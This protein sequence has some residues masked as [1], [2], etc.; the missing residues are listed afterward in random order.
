MRLMR[1]FLFALLLQTA[2]PASPK[3]ILRPADFAPLT[4]LPW[5]APDAT[6]EGSLRAIFREPDAS[7]RY[8]VLAEYLWTIP[9]AQLGRA[10]DLSLALEG[11][12]D[13]NELVSSFLEIWAARDPV[14]CWKRTQDLFQVTGF[15]EDW[16]S[17]SDWREPITVQDSN[18]IQ[19]SPYWLGSSALEGFPMGVELSSA[20]KK[21]R[22]RLMREFADQW[23]DAFATWPGGF[24]PGG[25][26]G[27]AC[28]PAVIKAFS[29]SM[30]GFATSGQ[31]DSTHSSRGEVEVEERRWL[32]ADPA[33]AP[34]I[35]EKMGE[36]KQKNFKGD[37]GGPSPGTLLLWARIDQPGM[38]RWAASHD[39][40]KDDLAFEARAFL[41]SRVD[42]ATR[43]GW[44]AD[45]KSPP[46]ADDM[47]SDLLDQWAMWDPGAALSAA[48]ATN[49]FVSVADGAC[50]GAFGSNSTHYSLEA[51]K[52][53]DLGAICA[54]NPNYRNEVTTGS[55]WEEVLE[56]WG[57]IDVGEAAR[58]GMD[59]LIRIDPTDRDTT[60]RYF[61]GENM[62]DSADDMVRHTVGALRVWAVFRPKEMKDWIA[63]LKDPKMQKAL[64]W[65]LNHSARGEP[66]APGP[67][68]AG[69]ASGR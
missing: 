38:L 50:S 44:L 10:F 49:Y 26:D 3:V 7:V 31:L 18:A 6:L 68:T 14:A 56:A 5:K 35:I 47:T 29:I 61:A 66:D 20:P 22:V 12:Q 36:L 4:S 65:L 32:Q 13:P 21:E 34:A 17:Y 52:N 41:M 60:I 64:T 55:E 27:A 23:F 59:Y 2:D 43:A 46:A 11:T 19:T 9:V 69:K 25:N 57:D 16:M 51:I 33:S 48:L 37:P 40:R 67:A 8:P 39:P 53:F 15:D 54:N 45:A 30:D 28:D 62:D 24:A 58:Y 42:A 63:T 1:M